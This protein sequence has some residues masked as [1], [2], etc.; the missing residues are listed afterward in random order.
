MPMPAW[1]IPAPRLACRCVRRI[2]SARRGGPGSHAGLRHTGLVDRPR[3][4]RRSGPVLR[5]GC[6]MWAYK[7][8]QGLHFPDQLARRE[9]L[10]VY[11]SWC[12]GVEGNTTFYGLPAPR[13]VASW[14]TE[15]PDNFRFVFKLP[16]AITHEHHLRDVAADHRQFLERIAPLG[17]RAEQLWIQLPPSFGPSNVDAL[18]AFV[19]ALPQSHRYAVE[20]RHRAF[21]DDAQLEAHVEQLLGEHDVEWISLDTTT[22]YSNAPPGPAERGPRRQKPHLPRRLR[23]LTDHPIVRFVGT[24]DP[25][26]T[27][28]G[29]QPWLP[30]LAGWL[31]E[32]R[33]PTVFVHTPDNVAAPPLARRLYDDVRNEGPALDPLPQPIRAAPPVEEPTLFPDKPDDTVTVP[34]PGA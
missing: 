15:A 18:G 7:A 5:V 28:A 30:V 27:R 32:G 17:D 21:Y 16:R 2:S 10:G 31:A 19:Q 14:A 3:D 34:V 8:W 22:L 12:N 26:Q 33:S 13:T 4:A 24:D 20:L 11:A 25:D 1:E 23:A 9:Q 29:W 6:A